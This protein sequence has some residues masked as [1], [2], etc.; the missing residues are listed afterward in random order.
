MSLTASHRGATW[1]REVRAH[2]H[3]RSRGGVRA[4]SAFAIPAGLYVLTLAILLWQIGG[5]P[6]YV[7]N[8]E[9]YTSRDMLAFWANPSL[10]IFR[11]TDG[12]MTDSGTSPFIV[13][14]LWLAFK[15][16]GV[17]LTAL[18][19]PIALIAGLAVP[20]L[21]FVGRR[22]AGTPAATLA[23]LFMALTPSYILYARTATL[24]GL[25]VTFALATTLLLWRV[26]QRPGSWWGLVGLQA[27]LCVNTYGYAPLR[28]FWP[29]SLALLAWEL[30]WRRRDWRWFAPA[31]LVTA[32]VLPA[33]VIATRPAVRNAT[34]QSRQPLKAL[35]LYYNAGGEQINN[36][37]RRVD[38]YEPFLRDTTVRGEDG[39]VQA[40]KLELA[41]RLVA[42]NAADFANLLLDRGTTPALHDYWKPEGRLYTI[43]LVPFFLLGLARVAWRC[44]RHLSD[45]VLL[46]LFLGF[47]LPMLLT[48]RVHIGRLLFFLP[49]LLL[50]AALG[51]T[52][53]ASWLARGLTALARR[54]Q[55]RC[56][57]APIHRAALVALS[58]MLVLGVARSAWRDYTVE[59]MPRKEA[60]IVASLA[61]LVPVVSAR[62]GALVLVLDDGL[63]RE[64][65]ELAAGEYQVTLYDQYQFID[66]QT[67]GGPLSPSA[68][69]PT[70][71]YGNP[72]AHLDRLLALPNACMNLYYVAPPLAE[73]FA[74][75][76]A[77][78]QAS[79]GIPPTQ[80]LLPE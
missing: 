5:H 18:R 40:S 11:P 77:R 68:G 62:G 31:L 64:I 71:Y 6:G 75:T 74:S 9:Q 32:L 67:T 63:S 14:P 23:A 55:P 56:D 52:V 4:W 25:S 78:L 16:G 79:C 15:V 34:P 3:A 41:R 61:D 76:A 33:M 51:A 20:L 27:L 19:V 38:N 29:L 8:W 80:L 53:V 46:A 28:F 17:G 26:L 1:H 49:F 37:N 21:W 10:D 45:R 30:L 39:S 54:A 72:M 2:S 44:W 65:E 70:L 7:Y 24:V 35:E 36:M 58:A 48:S 57:P 60:R 47:G 43:L 50:I 73:Q 69:P 12:L 22:L 42:Q 13:L 59:P 66:L